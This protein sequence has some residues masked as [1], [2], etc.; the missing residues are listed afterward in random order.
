LSPDLFDNRGTMNPAELR[1][2]LRDDTA[3]LA[4]AGPASLVAWRVKS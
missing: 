3:V 2:I 4:G 1:S